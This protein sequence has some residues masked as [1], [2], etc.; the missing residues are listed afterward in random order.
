M[1]DSSISKKASSKVQASTYANKGVFLLGSLNSHNFRDMVYL[2]ICRRILYTEAS[3][4]SRSS[5]DLAA[6]KSTNRSRI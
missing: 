4:R 1:R 6:L 5:R 3:F 2:L